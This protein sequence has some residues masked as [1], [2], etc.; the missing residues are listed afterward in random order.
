M[1]ASTADSSAPAVAAEEW[2]LRGAL[3]RGEEAAFAQLVEALHGSMLRLAMV[4]VGDR[5]VAEEVVQDA[6]VGCCGSWT[7]SRAARR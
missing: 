1:T 3:R 2:E 4:H 6:W 7:A 5:T